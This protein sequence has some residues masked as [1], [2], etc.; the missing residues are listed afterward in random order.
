MK[1]EV[2]VKKA[3]KGF[4]LNYRN[5]VQALSRIVTNDDFVD[6]KEFQELLKKERPPAIF[7]TILFMLL[8]PLVFR[9]AMYSSSTAPIDKKYKIYETGNATLDFQSNW[10][11]VDCQGVKGVTLNMVTVGVHNVT[12]P[13]FVAGFPSVAIF[14]SQDLKIWYNYFSTMSDESAFEIDVS[15]GYISNYDSNEIEINSSFVSCLG[16]VY[17]NYLVACLNLGNIAGTTKKG[18]TVNGPP[19]NDRCFQVQGICGVPCV[20]L[21]NGQYPPMCEDGFLE[22]DEMIITNTTEVLF[23]CIVSIWICFES[24]CIALNR[25]ASHNIAINF[26]SRFASP[27]SAFRTA[28]HTARL[29]LQSLCN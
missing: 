13:D 20:D 25:H 17:N 12:N 22:R 29:L 7:V 3:A 14:A 16:G 15:K 9:Y 18:E 19:F 1:P 5:S 2:K 4:D 6:T 27:F 10:K 26:L 23:S 11:C 28:C 21:S 24:H 8:S